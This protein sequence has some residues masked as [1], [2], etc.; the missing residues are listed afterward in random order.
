MIA[1]S[2]VGTGAELRALLG[3]RWQ[4]LRT[5]RSRALALLAA[6]LSIGVLVGG[7]AVAAQA[8]RT[9]AAEAGTLLPTVLLALIVVSIL[10]GIASG[11]GTEIV[12]ASQVVA[13]PVSPR[14]VYVG[15]ALLMPLNLAWTVQL[16]GVVWVAAY[17]SP[18][19]PW[20][21]VSVL[22]ML[23][24]VTAASTLGLAVSWW[25]TGVRLTAP[26]RRA[27]EVAGAAL[28]AGALWLV[29]TDRFG[30]FLDSSPL[31]DLVVSVI[32]PTRPQTLAWST[33]LVL[34]VAAGL[35]L[36]SRA[37]SWTLRRRE[38]T[39]TAKEG[40][41]VRSRPRSARV[42][43]HLVAVDR[44]SIWRSRPI[45]RGV[46]VLGLAPGAAAAI[47]GLSWADIAILPGLVASGAALLFGVNAFCLD[48]TG[49]AW[50]ESTP[51]SP[52]TAFWAKVL[53]TA[54]VV[55]VAVL[56]TVV[57]AGLRA[58]G[59][60]DAAAPGLL[61]A[62]AAGIIWP[63][64]LA[65]RSSVRRPHKA[66]LR[67][68]RDTPG[69]PAAMAAHALRLSV[70]A[71]FAGLA[72]S[73]TIRLEAPTAALVIGGILT[74]TACAHLVRTSALWRRDTMRSAVVTR[75]AFG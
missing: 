72:F 15:S 24:F 51:R 12:P 22:L 59:P 27:T 1:T 25:V 42:F 67:G 54:E 73:I 13:Y 52:G 56:L 35:W 11:G 44:A 60:V 29:A 32:V 10:S 39:W 74:L 31:L 71:T 7:V 33:G 48:G 17:I 30:A 9:F 20:M 4:M 68:P 21:A 47:G 41:S 70:F 69:P 46:L 2:P 62:V 36:G 23:G 3:L 40:R 45:R 37:T 57:V 64:A 43:R 58:S 18:R 26:G 55:T 63:V 34:A 6:G 61:A 8:P 65:L 16:V 50:L 5:R 38:D 19:S 75:V 49:A 53:V 28:A 14:T 66:D